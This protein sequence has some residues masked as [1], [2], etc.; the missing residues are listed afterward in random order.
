MTYTKENPS[1]N[2]KKFSSTYQPANRGKRKSILNNIDA[3]AGEDFDV[4]FSKEDKLRII[5]T[6]FEKTKE[7]LQ[8]MAENEGNP[9]FL[10]MLARA[11]LKDAKNSKV[12]IFEKIMDRVY[13]RPTTKHAG[14]SD[15]PPIGMALSRLSD[16]EIDEKLA[17]LEKANEAT[18]SDK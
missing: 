3:F 2:G 6:L 17:K 7:E 15:L 9:M 5:E 10:R 12:E 11:L 13:G 8:E 4:K 14:D 1:K 16:E 18:N